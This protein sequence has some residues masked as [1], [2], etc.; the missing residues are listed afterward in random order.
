MMVAAAAGSTF[1]PG[2]RRREFSFETDPNQP[3]G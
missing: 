2:G 1:W 3:S